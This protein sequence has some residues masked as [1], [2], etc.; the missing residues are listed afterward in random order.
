MRVDDEREADCEWPRKEALE[1]DSSEEEAA[2]EEES[3]S[4]SWEK[5]R[6]RCLLVYELPLRDFDN[7][8]V[9]VRWRVFAL[10]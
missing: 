6:L 7:L 2:E 8:E 3:E 1:E 4:E 10:S 5:E 9:F